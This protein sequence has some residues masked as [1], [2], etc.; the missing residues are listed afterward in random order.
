[1]KRA[2]LVRTTPL[3]RSSPLSR[4]ETRIKAKNAKRKGHRFPKPVCEPLREFVRSLPCVLARRG[5]WRPALIWSSRFACEGRTECAHLKSRGSGG[6]DRENMIPLCTRHHAMQHA[7]G[8][9]S[10]AADLAVDL[11]DLARRFTAEFDRR[12]A[13]ASPPALPDPFRGSPR[14]PSPRR[15]PL[16]AG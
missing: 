6:A 10:F 11:V 16:G 9:K 2:E 1:M 15:H 4:G 13:A 8:A 14:P 7:T 12:N 3:R 5:A